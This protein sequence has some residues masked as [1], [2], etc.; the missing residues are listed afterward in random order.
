VTHEAKASEGQRG[1][2]RDN[3]PAIAAAKSQSDQKGDSESESPQPNPP[4]LG[5]RQDRV[6][7]R[8]IPC[9]GP[10]FTHF[11]GRKEQPADRR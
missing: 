4:E 6:N 7:G 1:Q 10:A 9:I 5:I 8:Q 3:R 2:K 11:A